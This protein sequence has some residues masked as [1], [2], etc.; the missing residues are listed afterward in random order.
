MQ[1]WLD[2]NDSK[3]LM[4]NFNNFAKEY[5]MRIGPTQYLIP[6]EENERHEEKHLEHASLRYQVDQ[7]EGRM[8][9]AYSDLTKKEIEINRLKSVVNQIQER[10]DKLKREKDELQTKLN[11]VNLS[12]LSMENQL[13]QLQVHLK[14]V[15][16]HLNI[17][18][19]VTGNEKNPKINNNNNNNKTQQVTNRLYKNNNNKNNNNNNNNKSNSNISDRT[20][21]NNNNNNKKNI[22]SMNNNQR[23]NKSVGV[24]IEKLKRNNRIPVISLN[25]LEWNN[26]DDRVVNENM[27]DN[28]KQLRIENEKLK[29]RLTEVEKTESV[30]TNIIPSD[31]YR[32]T[33][34]DQHITIL[35]DSENVTTNHCPSIVLVDGNS[36]DSKN[37]INSKNLIINEKNE[38]LFL[39]INETDDMNK[40]LLLKL[41]QITKEVSLG[42][43]ECESIIE[44]MK[45][46]INRHTLR[47]EKRQTFLDEMTSSTTTETCPTIASSYNSIRHMDD[48]ISLPSMFTRQEHL[49]FESLKNKLNN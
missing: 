40:K 34:D 6:M 44:L 9:H 36:T 38:D 41:N 4:S 8:K 42:E 23:M 45:F 35:D 29:K 37:S 3:F 15:D 33:V 49:R 14:R 22:V 16:N 28:L 17:C 19:Q 32:R 25:N 13:E 20:N 39:S 46:K 43:S 2:S 18:A 21:N 24:K 7:L 27:E 12:K 1:D 5:E 26:E 47:E 10:E 48:S 30:Q 31:Y 11:Q